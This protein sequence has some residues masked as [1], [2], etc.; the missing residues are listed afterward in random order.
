[1]NRYAISAVS[2]SVL[3]GLVGV[4]GRFLQSGGMTNEEVSMIRFLL[5]ALFFGAVSLKKDPRLFRFRPRDIW[6]FVGSGILGLFLFSFCYFVAVQF[7]PLS[8]VSTFG[9]TTPVFVLIL[10]QIFLREKISFKKILAVIV[11]IAGCALTTGLLT[12]SI[13]S[14]GYILVGVLVGVSNALYSFFSS[15]ATK[16]GYASE[17]INFYSWILAAICGF[18]LWPEARPISGML[19]SLPNVLICLFLGFAV[20]FLA[21]YLYVYSFTGLDTGT[22]SILMS[23]TPLVAAVAGALIFHE[24]LVW[25]Q[26]LG[27]LMIIAAVNI[28][29]RK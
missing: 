3:Y 22:A 7:L 26:L 8:V 13:P 18:L 20:G 27:M 19:L 17:T 12:D 11:A 1:M 23:G 25:S 4:C 15:L 2:A 21:N 14:G 10:S 16:R 5:A 29:N 28:I 24:A 9:A 6:L